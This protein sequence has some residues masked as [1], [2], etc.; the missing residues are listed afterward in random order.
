MK[1]VK[2]LCLALF[3]S[4][5]FACEANLSI[6][7]INVDVLNSKNEVSNGEKLKIKI[8]VKDSEGIDFILIDIP[9]INVE[10]KIEDYSTDNKWTFEEH[11]EVQNID[12]TG[13]YEV[14]ITVRDNNG[15]EYV[16]TEEFKIQ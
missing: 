15:E 12:V 9:V 7:T 3:V 14:F 6:N 11:F 10:R 1:I 5:F 2:C 16:D 8:K 13:I 4:F